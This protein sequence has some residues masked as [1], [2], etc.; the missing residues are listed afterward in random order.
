M[1][2]EARSLQPNIK[3]VLLAKLR[4]Y[5]SDLNNNKSELKKL[6]SGNMN[7]SARD[8]LLESG[9]ADAMTVWLIFYWHSLMMLKGHSLLCE[10]MIRRTGLNSNQW[11]F[12]L[13]EKIIIYV[14]N[15][16][17]TARRVMIIIM[18]GRQIEAPN[19]CIICKDLVEIL[20]W[21][22]YGEANTKKI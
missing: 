10:T 2:L 21:I 12:K 15:E 13:T 14:Y 16:V 19:Y 22:P 4:E 18:S 1:D 3:G 5:K 20:L 7:P 17:S 11:S 6:V 8:M 9:M